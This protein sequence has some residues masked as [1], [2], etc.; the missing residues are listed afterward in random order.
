MSEGCALT[1]KVWRRG[2]M[3]GRALQVQDVYCRSPLNPDIWTE[4]GC[5]ADQSLKKCFSF[6]KQDEWEPQSPDDW[7]NAHLD[8]VDTPCRC[9]GAPGCQLIAEL[10]PA[11]RVFLLLVAAGR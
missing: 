5:A 7:C 9:V 1:T 4:S 2:C 6:S 3:T 10:P 11:A 8:D